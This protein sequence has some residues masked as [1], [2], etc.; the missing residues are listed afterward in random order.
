MSRQFEGT[1]EVDQ[2][3]PRKLRN[4]NRMQVVLEAPYDETLFAELV[5]FN[6]TA[7]KVFMK[8]DD[9]GQTDLFGE[10]EGEGGIED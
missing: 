3:K 1:F 9:E 8:E 7:V 4:G 10:G 2:V 5:H 6:F